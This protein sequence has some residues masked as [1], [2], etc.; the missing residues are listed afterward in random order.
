M[1]LRGN[2]F[3]LTA[4]FIWGTTFVAQMVGM[5]ALGPFSYAAAR[6]FLGF[7]SLSAIYYFFRGER[8][9]RRKQGL[10]FSGWKAGLGAGAVMFVATSLQQV[11][12]LYTTVGKAAFITSLYIV[13]VPIIAVLLKQ[14]IRW[15]NWLGA[16]L[17]VTGLYFLCM[18]EEFSLN[19]G[20]M[21]LLISSVFWSGH[22]LFIDHFAGEVDAIELSTAQIAVCTIF[23]LFPALIW[24]EPSLSALT[25]AWW[26]IFYGGVMSAGIAFTLQIIGQSYAE[27][28]HAA[29]IM[30]FEAIFGALAGWAILGEA[31][32]ARE[33]GGC[34]LMAA[35]MIVTQLGAAGKE[36][37]ISSAPEKAMGE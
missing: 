28:S 9:R 34:V 13:L 33:I 15:Q 10:Y 30:S 3:L 24:E 36:Q 14:H 22:I 19:F 37:R 18:N 4:A 25:A 11:S 20:D 27:P 6:Y 29:I 5:D 2:L 23:S 8:E 31:M 32:T 35:G 12:M 17:A 16:A 1:R 21:L 7:L 26:P